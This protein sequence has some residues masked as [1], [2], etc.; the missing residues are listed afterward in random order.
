VKHLYLLGVVLTFAAAG[1]LTAQPS[2]ATPTAEME[3]AVRYGAGAEPATGA[4]PAFQA[5]SPSAAAPRTLRAHTHVY[6]AFAATWLLLFGYAL[7]VGRRARRIEE[8]LARLR[9]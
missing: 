9:G 4:P 8:E 6:A 2:Q 1:P 7:S 5:V 3:A